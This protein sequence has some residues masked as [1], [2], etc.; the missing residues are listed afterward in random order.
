MIASEF[1][2]RQIGQ[3]FVRKLLE[4]A[5]KQFR[6]CL[7]QTAELLERFVR[8]DYHL[9]SLRFQVVFLCLQS[10]LK[11]AC[12]ILMPIRKDLA[13]VEFSLGAKR[14]QS[15]GSRLRMKLFDIQFRP[16]SRALL[17]VFGPL[18]SQVLSSLTDVKMNF[19]FKL[20]HL[21]AQRF[22]RQAHQ[23]VHHHCRFPALIVP[24]NLRELLENPEVQRAIPVI[25][26]QPK[27][28]VGVNKLGVV[29]LIG[30]QERSDLW[31]ILV[32]HENLHHFSQ[33][34]AQD[35]RERGIIKQ[36][37]CIAAE[38]FVLGKSCQLSRGCLIYKSE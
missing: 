33:C 6:S 17:K 37:T 38:F 34:D 4:Q 31:Y 32:L 30:F 14:K 35:S 13:H 2:L 36:L 15:P 10:N 19:L 7:L 21:L 24:I 16:V 12:F 20:D 18:R 9:I 5:A 11:S 8:S 3:A 1:L 26:D 29:G 27:L 25:A 22:R 23:L 28:G